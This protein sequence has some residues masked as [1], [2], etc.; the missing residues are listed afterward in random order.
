MDDFLYV[1][2][3][4][5]RGDFAGDEDLAM[6]AANFDGDARFRIFREIGVEYG[7][8]NLV[9]EFVGMTGRDALGG[10]ISC[11]TLGSC[12]SIHDPS[13]AWISTKVIKKRRK[14]YIIYSK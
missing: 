13:I 10:A 3:F 8:R 5:G 4:R 11:Y 6:P 12:V 1:D 14:W 2:I 7:V 9:A